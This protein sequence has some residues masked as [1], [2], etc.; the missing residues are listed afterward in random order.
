MPAKVT[1]VEVVAVILRLLHA[2]R[3]SAAAGVRAATQVEVQAA[4]VRGVHRVQAGAKVSVRGAERV[5]VLDRVRVAI[6]TA[7]PPAKVTA[8][9]RGANTRRVRAAEMTRR[10]P[11][12]AKAPEALRA[13]L[14]IRRQRGREKKRRA[15]LISQ[16][17][18]TRKVLHGCG[19]ILIGAEH[20][21]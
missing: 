14:L 19:M 21:R 16:N 6:G 4:A 5:I 7:I 17:T 9:A 10:C 8:E 3:V 1:V 15:N 20:H 11:S 18:R 12:R 2:A 13:S